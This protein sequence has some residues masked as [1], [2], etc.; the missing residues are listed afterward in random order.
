M[1]TAKDDY[2]LIL[3]IAI[4]SVPL[5]L[6]GNSI[7]RLIHGDNGNLTRI[8]VVYTRFDDIHCIP[9]HWHGLSL[10]GKKRLLNVIEDDCQFLGVHMRLS[11]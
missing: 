7:Q 4:L 11:A 2:K 8:K 6:F 5:Y 9:D 3:S 1:E 10:V